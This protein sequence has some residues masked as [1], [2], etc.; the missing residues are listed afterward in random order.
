TKGAGSRAPF[1]I[2][3]NWPPCKQTNKRPSGAKSIEVG[4]ERPLA[5]TVSENPE[6]KVAANVT[7]FAAIISRP[8]AIAGTIEPV[9]NVFGILKKEKLAKHL[10]IIIHPDRFITY[11]RDPVSFLDS[12]LRVDRLR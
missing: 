2:T 4:L 12:A 5:V 9:L 3:R 8:K 1:L 7:P 6:G 11:Q 10:R